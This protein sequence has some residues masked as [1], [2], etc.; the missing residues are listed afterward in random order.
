MANRLQFAGKCMTRL[1][2]TNDFPA[3]VLTS[4]FFLVPLSLKKSLVKSFEKP[5]DQEILLKQLP[6]EKLP[7]EASS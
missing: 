2:I 4:L 1:R 3:I 6:L 5:K 7:L